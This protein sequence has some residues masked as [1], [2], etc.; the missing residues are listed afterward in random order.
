[1][2]SLI[3]LASLSTAAPREALPLDAPEWS[4]LGKNLT[5]GSLGEKR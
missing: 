4:E 5:L 1:M 2:L 3:L